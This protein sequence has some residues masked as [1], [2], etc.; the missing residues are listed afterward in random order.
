MSYKPKPEDIDIIIKAAKSA[1]KKVG[2]VVDDYKIKGFVSALKAKL[3]PGF[4]V[5]N[6][7]H[8]IKGQPLSAIIVKRTTPMVV[9][10]N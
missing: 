9:S 6:A 5:T 3:P 10:S 8:V 1:P 7:G 4:E 2:L